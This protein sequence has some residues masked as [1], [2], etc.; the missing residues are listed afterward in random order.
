MNAVDVNQFVRRRLNM[1]AATMVLDPKDGLPVEQTARV[2]GAAKSEL[3]NL[4]VKALLS[5]S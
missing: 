5:G 3:L 2:K 4:A 1:K